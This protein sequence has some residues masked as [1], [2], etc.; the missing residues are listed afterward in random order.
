MSRINDDM[1]A[2]GDRNFVTAIARGFE[3]LRCFRLD[4]TTLTN[5]E[6]ASRTRLPKPTV[7]RLTYTLCKLGYLVQSDAT[8]AYRLGAGVL[9]LGFSALAG[10]EIGALA[11]QE[12]RKLCSGPNP[13][14]TAALAER[15][16]L[17]VIYMAVR[18]SNQAVSLTMNVGARLPLFYSAIGRAVLVGMP[19]DERE[20]MLQLAIR[21]H[22]ENEAVIRKSLGEAQEDFAKYG[23]TTSFGKW[24]KE[25]NG[26][27]VPVEALDGDRIYG[28]NVGGPSFL[29]S[30]DILISEYGSRLI[31]SARMI[32]RQ[33]TG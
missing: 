32:G 29:V 22:P 25:V 23:F 20:E 9:A 2:E 12:M 19:Q 6:I 16:R 28:L 21:E 24:R 26:I 10:M 33:G 13:Y 17:Q 8:G 27:A 7:S 11:K 14:V 15:H 4:E 30:P 3:V 5:Q 31:E 18:R 1:E